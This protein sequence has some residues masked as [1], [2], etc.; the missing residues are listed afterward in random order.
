MSLFRSFFK[1]EIGLVTGAGGGFALFFGAAFGL[2]SGTGDLGGCSGDFTDSGTGESG[3]CSDFAGC[4]IGDFAGCTIDD[5]AG[6]TIGDLGRSGD[7]GGGVLGGGDL[8]ALHEEADLGRS[9]VVN[10]VG[11]GSSG[12]AS[13]GGRGRSGI[14]ER[15]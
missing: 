14:L 6:C 12:G 7:F 4:T 13:R 8:G 10:N 9:G 2:R 3:C 11:S 1:T 15:I 5:F